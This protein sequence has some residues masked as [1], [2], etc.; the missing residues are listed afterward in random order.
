M[1][2]EFGL[3]F[4]QII[5]F[6]IMLW[7]MNRFA[8]KPLL[9]VLEERRNKIQNEFA[10]IEQQKNDL[11][12]LTEDYRLKMS[13]IGQEAK[14]KIHQAIEEGQRLSKQIQDETYTEAKEIL[15]K[16]RHDV[17][18]QVEEAKARLKNEVVQIA[19]EATQKLIKENVDTPKN[20]KL[21]YDFVNKVEFK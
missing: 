10:T 8:W 3:I 5:A 19:L 12:H 2:I 21:V 20:R 9:K 4:T 7:V 14:T 13:Q 11:Q 16:A 6:L 1:D 18:Q 15:K 17:Q